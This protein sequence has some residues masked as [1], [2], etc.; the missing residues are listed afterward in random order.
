MSVANGVCIYVELKEKMIQFIHV[1]GYFHK[2]NSVVREYV[3]VDDGFIPAANY[4]DMLD[5]L[6]HRAMFWKRAGTFIKERAVFFHHFFL[7][8]FASCCPHT[9][10]P[11]L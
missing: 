9:Y 6:F 1:G 11:H 10:K 5:G 2:T 8:P 7:L 4:P 3:C